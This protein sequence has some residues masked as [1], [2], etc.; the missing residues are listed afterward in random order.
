MTIC[1]DIGA[2]LYVGRERLA[3]QWAD[4]YNCSVTYNGETDS[5]QTWHSLDEGSVPFGYPVALAAG[6]STPNWEKPRLNDIW[7]SNVTVG[8]GTVPA[9][10]VK[11][12]KLCIPIPGEE[13]VV[14]IGL[15]SLSSIPTAFPQ[16]AV[17]SRVEAFLRSF[18]S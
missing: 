6:D 10:L 9:S 1:A 2:G 15:R 17:R 12:P 16:A 14:R 8:T 18:R 5:F 11:V 3:G 4:H 7:Y 13:M